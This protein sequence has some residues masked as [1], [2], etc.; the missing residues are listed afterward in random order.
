MTAVGEGRKEGG[1]F[2]VDEIAVAGE[3]EL[4]HDLVLHEARKIRGGG[5]AIPGQISSVTAHPPTSS[6][7]SSTRTFFPRFGE[8]SGGDESVMAG[9]DNEDVERIG[10]LNFMI[11]RRDRSVPR[12]GC[13]MILK[14]QVPVTLA[15]KAS[16]LNGP[17]K[18]GSF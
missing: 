2:G 14:T 15:R 17:T 3:I 7:A 8:I 11:A 12:D 9:A 10:H 4:A 5:D 13:I 6:R 1:V 18:W 16:R